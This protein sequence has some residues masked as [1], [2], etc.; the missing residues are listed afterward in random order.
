MKE[1]YF[2]N[3]NGSAEEISPSGERRR[4]VRFPVHISVQ[5]GE[6]TP[7]E[8]TSFILN[9][10]ERGV[11]IETESPLPTGTKIVMSFY[12]PPNAKTLANFAGNVKWINDGES[13]LPKGM[14]ISLEG[15]SIEAIQQLEDFMEEREHLVDLKE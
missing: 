4:S 8:Y 3:L 2:L 14:G 7:V 15:Y 11:F 13:E 6:K 10:S 12:I 9:M 1:K 5:Y